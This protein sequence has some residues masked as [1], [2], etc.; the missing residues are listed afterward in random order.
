MKSHIMA[1]SQPATQG[2]AS[3]CSDDRLAAGHDRFG[4]FGEKI[5]VESLGKVALC[6]LADIGTG[7]KGLF[8]PGHDR[9]AH[10]IVLFG[11]LQRVD[12]LAQELRVQ[13]IQGIG[14]VSRIRQTW[15]SMSTISVS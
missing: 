8:R 9:T 7:G 4:L 11:L 6:H 1:S 5:L 13:G 2:I 10:G 14:A 15:S 3:N 12:Q